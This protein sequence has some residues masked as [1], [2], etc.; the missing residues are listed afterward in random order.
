MTVV[1]AQLDFSG[2]TGKASRGGK[3]EYTAHWIVKTNDWQDQPFTILDY[4]YATGSLPHPDKASPYNYGNDSD[5][6]AIC[7]SLDPRREGDSG[8]VW[9]VAAHFADDQKQE[10]GEDENGNPTD[11][12]ENFA[13]EIDF[14]YNKVRRPAITGEYIEG[15]GFD[16]AQRI[17]GV[18]APQ[19][20]TNSAFVPYDPPLERDAVTELLSIT[21]NFVGQVDGQSMGRFYNAV[22]SEA[23]VIFRVNGFSYSAEKYQSKIQDIKPVR[24]RSAG[25]L[26]WRITFEIETDREFGWR[27]KVLDQGMHRRQCAGDPDGFGGTIS[28]ASLKNGQARHAAI[29]D[30]QGHPVTS[31]VLLNGNGQPLDP[32]LEDPIFITWRIYPERSYQTIPLLNTVVQ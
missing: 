21:G 12:P 18:P 11:N 2:A 7:D 25:L 15:F 1:S 19:P 4:F 22:N 16:A 27:Q 14:R 6:R 30:Q 13:L 3:R 9:R 28:S 20:I 29:L 26:F 23:Y 17:A 31:P 8:T 24:K 5:P 10:E 32:C